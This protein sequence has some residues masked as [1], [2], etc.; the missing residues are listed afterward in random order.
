MPCRTQ[1]IG[2][3]HTTVAA[4]EAPQW[5]ARVEHHLVVIGVRAGSE[6]ER[7][8]VEAAL[9]PEAP[10]EDDVGVGRVDRN[11]TRPLVVVDTL[12]AT[13]QPPGGTTV[14]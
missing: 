13:A 8:A 11:E 4:H 9:E 2:A 14:T 5:V 1:V 7:G 3:V 6:G 12:T 10:E